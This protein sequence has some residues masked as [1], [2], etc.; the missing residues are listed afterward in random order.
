MIVIS[1]TAKMTGG[2]PIMRR[3]VGQRRLVQ[4]NVAFADNYGKCRTVQWD[5]FRSACEP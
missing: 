4:L 2:G 5:G 1:E 3:L